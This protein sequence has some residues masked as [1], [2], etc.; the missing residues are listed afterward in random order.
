MRYVAP[1]TY[2]VRLNELDSSAD[3]LYVYA[4][5]LAPAAQDDLCLFSRDKLDSQRPYLTEEEATNVW[6]FYCKGLT[7]QKLKLLEPTLV[8][9]E[10]GEILKK[11]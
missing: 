6:I 11:A 4:E 9:V 5:A 10:T 1:R 7:E 8:D 3:N 2:T